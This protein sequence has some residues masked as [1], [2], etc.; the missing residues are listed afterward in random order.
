MKNLMLG[1]LLG[2]L[3]S[4]SQNASAQKSEK[5]A[6]DTTKEATEK[7]KPIRDWYPFSGIVSSVDNKAK[8]ISLSKKDGDRVVQI[9][10][11]STFES[12]GKAATLG[13]IKAGNYLHGKLRKN[14]ADEEVVFDAKIEPEAPAKKPKVVKEGN[15]T[16]APAKPKR[17]KGAA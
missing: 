13:D 16:N 6:K 4:V 9:D 5:P 12:N 10:S 15:G 17:V 2:A 1:A 11:K 3:L 14:A 8:T 7:A